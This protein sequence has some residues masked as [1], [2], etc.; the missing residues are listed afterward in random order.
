MSAQGP[1]T[2]LPHALAL[3]YGAA[4][5]FASLQPF[6]PWIAPAAD[7]P[8]W[9]FAAWPLRWTRYD[10]AANVIAYIPFG[11]FLAL[12]PRRAT[13]GVRALLAMSVGVAL[14]FTMETLQMYLPP[15]DASLVDLVANS[16]GALV[17]GIA[18]ASLVRAQR[19]RHALSGARNRLFLPGTLGDVGLALLTLWL[20]AHVNP[21]IPLFAVTFDPG[22]PPLTGNPPI[23]AAV[24]AP[25][26]ALDFIAAT[27]TTFQLLGIGLFLILLL[28]DR[29][30]IGGAVLVLVG[31]ALLAKGV[32]ALL[33]LKPVV[34]PTW[35][36][37]GVT[38]G[39][40]AGLVVLLGAVFLP[41]PAQVAACAVALL[42]SLLLPIL[43]VDLPSARAPFTLFNW[44]YGHLLTFNGLTQSVLLVWPLAAAGWLFA[45]AGQP[46]WG[47]AG[48][49][50]GL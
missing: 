41:R 13:R 22:Q 9:L 4:I 1:R 43:A 34:W 14:S 26:V 17:G 40:A 37:P 21:G 12:V 38:F 42:A 15:R 8:F 30:D 24:L 50:G 36:K 5:A 2:L 25:D 46:H 20:V 6:A 29:R 3:I 44:R 16:M 7:V 39:M 45:L 11:L 47:K 27:V 49:E 48:P 33:V 31:V 28:R 19:L 10:V 32:A 35:L 23:A 18:G